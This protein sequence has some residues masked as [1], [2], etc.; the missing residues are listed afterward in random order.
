MVIPTLPTIGSATPFVLFQTMNWVAISLVS[1]LFVA[2]F[3]STLVVL[4]L[5]FRKFCGRTQEQ[6]E[7]S[8]CYRSRG[9]NS[10]LLFVVRQL[11]VYTFP[12]L[13]KMHKTRSYREDTQTRKFMLFLDRKVESNVPLIAAFCSIVC[14][15]FFTSAAV[16]FQ[17]FPVEE[18]AECLEKD[19]HGRTLFC[20]SNSSLPV[21]CAN[22]SV[23]ELRELKFQCYAIALPVGLGIAVAAAFGLAEV[24]IVGVTI[25]V[26]VTEGIFNKIRRRLS[27]RTSSAVTQHV[28]PEGPQNQPHRCSCCTPSHANCVFIFSSI[29]LII[30]VFIL[31]SSCAIYTLINLPEA[32]RRQPLDILYYP[33]YLFLPMLI[34]FPLAYIVLDLKAHCSRGEYISFAPDQRPPDP[35]D[36]DMESEGEHD[37]ASCFGSGCCTTNGRASNETQEMGDFQ[38]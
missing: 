22:F 1:V 18:S 14:C 25:F 26:K 35:S 37:E 8:N 34:C 7:R 6:H 19:N 28:H 36:W 23:T 12:A 31:S 30:I 15:I 11:C 24:G 5:C 13:F 33:A 27:H 9:I 32:D 2:A 38:G 21:D 3:V 10:V 20:Y 17:Y 4:I 29:L 16:F